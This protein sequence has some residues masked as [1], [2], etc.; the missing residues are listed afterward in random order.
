MPA[1]RQKTTQPNKRLLLLTKENPLVPL[2]ATFFSLWGREG[3]SEENKLSWYL[4]LYLFSRHDNTKESTRFDRRLPT[5]CFLCASC[6]NTQST[7]NS[8]SL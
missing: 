4:Y 7:G 8:L 3:G 6:T 5:P 1:R 2:G